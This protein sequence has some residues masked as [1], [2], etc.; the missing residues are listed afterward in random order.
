MEIDAALRCP[1]GPAAYICHLPIHQDGSCNGLQHYAALGRDQSGA[2]SVNLAPAD[3]PGD[4]YNTV[5]TLVERERA[6][7]EATGN[8]VALMLK[9]HVSRPI[10]KQTVM[11]VVYGV[12]RFGARLQIIKQLKGESDVSSAPLIEDMQ[13]PISK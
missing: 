2:E 4:V 10:V 7:D 3:R 9:G 8:S 12:T 6:K 11:T 13:L 1:D 5:A